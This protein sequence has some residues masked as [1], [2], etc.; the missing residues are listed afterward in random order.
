MDVAT[1]SGGSLVAVAIA[2]ASITAG[3]L[4]QRRYCADVDLK[5]AGLVQFGASVMVL[6]PLAVAVEGFVVHWDW[7]LAA[8]VAFLVVGGSILAVNALHTLMRH[9][10]AARVTTLLYLTPIVAVILE[11]ILFGVVPAPTAIAGIA[12]TCAGVAL[13][14]A[15][16]RTPVADVET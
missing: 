4:Y 1:A 6:A 11:R 2:L 9:G 10:H 5:T 8:A 14:T 12:V 16:R 13:V 3:T 15:R 7:R